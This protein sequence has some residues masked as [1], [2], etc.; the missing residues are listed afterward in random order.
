MPVALHAFCRKNPRAPIPETAFPDPYL[1]TDT[2]HRIIDKSGLL[3]TNGLISHQ[4]SNLLERLGGIIEMERR[5]AKG[6]TY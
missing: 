3:N 1:F 5:L 6:T 2:E 4:S